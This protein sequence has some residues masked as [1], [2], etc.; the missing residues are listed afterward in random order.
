L[1]IKLETHLTYGQSFCLRRPVFCTFGPPEDPKGWKY[2]EFLP[3]QS[4]QRTCNNTAYQDIVRDS[5]RRIGLIPKSTWQN[6]LQRHA[7]FYGEGG[8]SMYLLFGPSMAA[9][10]VI[11]VIQLR[12]HFVASR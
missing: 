10:V 7:H 5:A 3:F 1:H 8:G 11:A 4:W 2:G 9:L 6:Q 12:D